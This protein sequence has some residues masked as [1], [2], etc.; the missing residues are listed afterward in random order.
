MSATITSN[1]DS[2]DATLCN[3][4]SNI[5]QD[6]DMSRVMLQVVPSTGAS[7]SHI[8]HHE[9]TPT[10]SPLRREMS[11]TSSRFTAASGEG[12]GGGFVYNNNTL[13]SAFPSSSI[14]SRCAT[15]LFSFFKSKYECSGIHHTSGYDS[16]QVAVRQT[17][18]P[19]WKNEARE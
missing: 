2:N 6:D 7:S 4:R 15:A 8:H 10:F 9:Y 17:T 12:G 19:L 14:S 5:S 1:G 16:E 18:F 13:P 3:V 11:I